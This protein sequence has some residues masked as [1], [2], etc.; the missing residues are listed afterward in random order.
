VG[1]SQLEQ[2]FY[3]EY[4]FANMAFPNMVRDWVAPCSERRPG[5]GETFWRYMDIPKFIYLLETKRLF[6]SRADLLGDPQEG[7]VTKSTYERVRITER[8][9]NMAGLNDQ[10]I[11]E[12]Q[13]LRKKIYVNCWH[14]AKHESEKMWKRY[15][16]F[17]QGVAV[18]TTSERLLSVITD[19]EVQVCCVEYRDYQKDCFYWE[20]QN[21]P[22]SVFTL[23]PTAFAD[24]REVRLLKLLSSQAEG[25]APVGIN[26]DVNLEQLIDGVYINPFSPEWHLPLVHSLMEKYN[27]SNLIPLTS[28]SPLKIERLP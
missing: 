27:A 14:T 9:F 5:D 13:G 15:C 11:K 24:D 23:K 7:F 16:G 21:S 3:K 28:W 10:W 17:D 26:I 19:S 6:F 1:N 25:E 22:F 2:E 12:R 4:S 20:M 8:S 18:R